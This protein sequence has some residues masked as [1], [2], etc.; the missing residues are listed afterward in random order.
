MP[1]PNVGALVV[2]GKRR[3]LTTQTQL[4]VLAFCQLIGLIGSR[5]RQD[6]PD[7]DTR[8]A[9]P[10]PECRY[11][12]KR[13]SPSTKIMQASKEMPQK[14]LLHNSQVQSLHLDDDL[15]GMPMGQ[16]HHPASFVVVLS[17]LDADG[18]QQATVIHFDCGGLGHDR[19][20][21]IPK[22]NCDLN[23]FNFSNLFCIT[24]LPDLKEFLVWKQ[25]GLR[26]FAPGQSWMGYR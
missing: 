20:C 16:N 1:S 4:K 14:N 9:N 10:G 24:H 8:E 25:D 12:E 7:V 3:I 22:S 19:L 15:R 6:N 26:T 17:G 23:E 2:V 21:A 18:H 11:G 5:S 13:A